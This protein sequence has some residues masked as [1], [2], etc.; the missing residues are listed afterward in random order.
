M[1]EAELAALRRWALDMAPTG[2][3]QARQV[4][5]LIAEYERLRPPP[6]SKADG[7]AIRKQ[8][9]D[10]GLTLLPPAEH[11]GVSIVTLSKWERAEGP[12]P[13]SDQQAILA[14]FYEELAADP[15]ACL[16]L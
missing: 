14:R 10:L 9:T 12:G 7:R 15:A 5:A 2:L 6:W 3:V 8:R 1:T 16:D 11:L 13:T 4:L